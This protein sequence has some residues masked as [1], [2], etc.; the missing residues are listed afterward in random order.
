MEELLRQLDVIRRW[1][2]LVLAVALIAAASAL[3]LSLSREST[4]TAQ[5]TM[6]VGSATQAG[7]RAPEQDA[8]LARGYSEKLN[9]SDYQAAI[10]TAAGVPDS[11]VI[12]AVPVASSPILS[13]VATAP[14]GEEAI[15]S[16]REFALK[17]EA[18]VT[19]AFQRQYEARVAPLRRQ[20]TDNATDLGAARAEL[21]AGTGLSEAERVELQGR[22]EQ[23]Q[24]ERE[25]LLAQF[26][27]IRGASAN[28]NLVAVL[29]QPETSFENSP[30]IMG[31]TILG[32]IGGTILG[33]AI[34][35]VLGSLQA[36]IASPESVRARLQL[37]TL[38]TVS[39]G[40]AR[41]RAEDLRALS[42][43]LA[44]MEGEPRTVAVASAEPKEGKSMVASNLARNR[45][46]LGDRV[47]LIDANL[48]D[49]TTAAASNG[50]GAGLSR[51]LGGNGNEPIEPE[52]VDSGVPNMRI[53]PAGPTP[54][55]P[56]ALMSEDRLRRVLDEVSPLADLVVV[57][58]PSL[59]SAPESQ[60]VCKLADQTI[61]V[62]DS[63]NTDASAAVDARDALERIHARILGVVLTRVAKR[64]AAA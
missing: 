47:I 15:R 46:S 56:Y 31:N 44:L 61:L 8:V 1:K 37:P 40:D 25:S 7:D 42:S 30:S 20:L 48:R 13:I 33:C 63:A 38:A 50:R 27:D 41:R 9:S 29:N 6:I 18:A 34:A 23:L 21:S 49:R 32:L 4:Y 16:A 22:I 24:A 14:N 17:W 60:V 43:G 10:R 45:A 26:T 53:L 39:N 28:P 3:L 35:L 11:V 54:S 64:R 19:Q 51:L 2:Y 59:L 62:V 57:D 52:L 36:R 5:A 58:T 55:D 12:E